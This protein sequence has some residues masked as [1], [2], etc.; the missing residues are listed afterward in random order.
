[1]EELCL[2][3]E[4]Y[5]Y[6]VVHFGMREQKALHNCRGLSSGC[7]GLQSDASCEVYFS[8]EEKAGKLFTTA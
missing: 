1:M 5:D 3:A 4:G 6:T 8:T 2:I 7:L